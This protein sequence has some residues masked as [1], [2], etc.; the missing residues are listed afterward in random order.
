MEYLPIISGTAA[1]AVL[2]AWLVLRG[3]EGVVRERLRQRDEDNRRL[4]EELA[5]L[6]AEAARLATLNAQ[7]GTQLDAERAAHERVT[8]EFKA[9]SA[10]AL[11]V[12]RVDFLAEARQAFGQLQQQSVGDLDQRRQAVI[13]F[14]RVGNPAA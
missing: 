10:D 8:T 3:R 13:E 2:I 4:G 7:L 12:N 6:R 1:L 11:R 14:C 9:L 5:E